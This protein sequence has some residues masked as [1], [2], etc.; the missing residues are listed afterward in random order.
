MVSTS[1]ISGETAADG[2][3]A[4]VLII[5]DE[6]GPRESLR[7]LLKT[8]FDV[9]CADSVDVGV[10]LLQEQRPDMVI[11]DIRMPG[12]NGIEGLRLIRELDTVVPVVMFTGFG[13][14]ET[15]Q[16]AIRLGAN[17][18]LKKPFDAFEIREVVR[19]HVRR[20]QIERRRL[21]A[22][23]ELGRLNDSLH[24]ELDRKRRMA[25]LG[26]MSAE[27]MHD[28]R[29][30]LT[31][32]M[33]YVD[34]LTSEL[35][36]MQNHLG[37]KWQDTSEYLVKIEDSAERCKRLADMWLDISKGR[38][39]R[40][41]ERASDIVASIVQDCR[42]LVDRRKVK[43][44]VKTAEDTVFHVDRLQVARA[45]QNLLV[46]SIEA[47]KAGEGWVNV[48][49]QR[50]GNNV[51]IG[52]EDN[53]CGMSPEQVKRSVEPFFS[54]KKGTGTGLGLFIARQAIEAHG[55]T[56]RIE[57]ETGKGTRIVVTVPRD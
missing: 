54:T 24:E 1:D 39:N 22:V 42:P 9:F 49:C 45:F 33:G 23:E 16:E 35:K 5:D 37:D 51:E 53:G 57:S 14:L 50:D 10:Q 40:S 29:N 47:V 41:A 25:E 12:K 48:W 17:D 31:A 11:M 44:T 36:D 20:C 7:I 56:M 52:V 21:Q 38:L 34:L 2:G 27:L 32:V 26:Q 13:A 15:A 3:R 46:N 55:G 30:P 19:K 8:E 18:Y 6:R 4:K 28:L 43:L